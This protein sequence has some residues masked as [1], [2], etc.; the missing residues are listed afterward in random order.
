M[1]SSFEV[2]LEFPPD[3]TGCLETI[4]IKK[5]ESTFEKQCKN[6]LATDGEY[7]LLGLKCYIRSYWP[8]R[9]GTSLPR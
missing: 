1:L 9:S 5:A 7:L 8:T 3:L 6:P 4:K 2:M